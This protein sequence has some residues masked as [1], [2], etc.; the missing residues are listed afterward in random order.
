VQRAVQQ[1]AEAMAAKNRPWLPRE[2]AQNTVNSLLPPEKYHNSLFKHLLIEGIISEDYFWQ[3]NNENSDG[4]RFS[5][6]RFSDHLI[7]K[8]LLDKYLDPDNP[9]T[10]FL[11]TSQLGLLLKDE[12]ACWDNR[13]FLEAFSIQLPERFGKEL[14]EVAPHCADYSIFRESFVQSLIW[15][16]PNSFSETTR[17]YINSHIIQDDNT[18]DLL[19]NALLTVASNVNH[20]YNADFLH[21]RLKR[22][23]MASRD[24]WWSTFLHFQYDQHEAVDR[25]VDWAW[26][27]EDKSH[28][29]DES[30]RL[31][32]IALAWFLT[33]SNRFLRD[34]ATKALVALL[35]PRIH[36]LRQV[37]SEFLEIDDLYVLERL[38]AV[39]YGCAMRSTDDTEIA[40]LAQNIYGWVFEK[41]KP[42]PHILL[43]DYARGVIE[44]ALSRNI[45]LQINVAQVR[46]PYKSEWLSYIPTDD[47][48]KVYTAQ[49]EEALK[50]N[51][52]RDTFLPNQWRSVFAIQRSV[53]SYGDFSRYI[54]GT[55][56][57][58]FSWSSRRLNEPPTEIYDDF[59]KSL[60]EKQRRA[61]KRY[62]TVLKNVEHYRKLELEERIKIFEHELTEQ[63]LLEA[64]SVTKQSLYKILGKKKT[65][66]FEESIVSYSEDLTENK[67]QFDLSIAQRWIFWR[68]FDLGWTV[69]RFGWF[70]GCLSSHDREANKAERI[71]KKYQWLAYHE[72]LARV[73]DNFKFKG[74]DWNSSDKKGYSGPWQDHARDIDPSCL[75]KSIKKE[76][77]NE[78]NR[79]WWLTV[80]YDSWN[81]HSNN[82]EWLKDIEDLPTTAPLIDIVNPK[83]NSPWLPLEI[84]NAWD[85]PV[86]LGEDYQAKREIWYMIKSYIVKKQDIDCL[87]EW[88]IHQD[89]MGRWMPEYQ[90]LTQVFLGEFFW[91]P[92]F[93]YHNIPYFSHDRWTSGRHEQLPRK[94][95]VTTDQYLKESS[96]FD[97]SVDESYRIY[98]PAKFLVDQMKLQWNGVD[99][100]F[101]DQAGNLIVYDPSVK[102][103]G[104]NMCLMNREALMNFLDNNGY[105]IFWTFLGEKIILKG[106]PLHARLELTGAFRLTHGKL[107]GTVNFKLNHSSSDGQDSQ[108][109]HV[110]KFAIPKNV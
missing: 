38:Y 17:Q 27:A 73:S 58:S 77:W 93:E 30:I 52:G 10:A 97:C 57:A 29:D 16:N 67:S 2:E 54:I 100:C 8:Y 39:S 40:Q 22:D 110:G 109:S 99:G 14:F 46:P 48:L 18:H 50:E 79:P 64:I 61:W 6:E 7:I 71:G 20:P 63:D 102:E 88:A 9:S 89:F 4:I 108:Q 87:Y 19:L 47:E 65:R 25:L 70:D 23:S 60:T 101:F 83:D 37:I 69:E 53:L 66:I 26:T 44:L 94:I 15:R 13:G 45:V 34:G 62:Q 36:I 107:E 81:M 78:Q 72:F 51:S 74:D 90:Q 103:T 3:G 92:A 24:A 98:L 49:A 75:L 31:C 68:V 85:E 95:L 105:D 12:W 41:G 59:L 56:S 91:S 76:D 86:P 96:D 32:A 80:S 21:K 11:P 35:T 106:N 28:I 5:Y 104:S 43:R 42:I 33:T 55:N 82:L 84:Y 1:L